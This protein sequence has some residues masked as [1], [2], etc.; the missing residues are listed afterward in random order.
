VERQGAADAKG[1]C[2]EGEEGVCEGGREETGEESCVVCV[3]LVL[4]ITKTMH[5]VCALR[6]GVPCMKSILGKSRLD[7]GCRVPD[8]MDAL[9]GAGW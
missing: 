1:G 4:S 3:V 5:T 9:W 2:E 8:A 7:V 6:H